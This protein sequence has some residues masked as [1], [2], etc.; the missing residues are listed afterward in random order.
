LL[1]PEYNEPKVTNLNPNEIYNYK[2]EFFFYHDQSYIIYQKQLYGMDHIAFDIF[3]RNLEF[4]HTI[5]LKIHNI[6][7]HSNGK[8]SISPNGRYI[9]YV[10]EVHETEDDPQTVGKL[11]EFMMDP[12]DKTFGFKL[13]ST[14]NDFK[15]R[16]DKMASE[17][18]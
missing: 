10:E 9:F 8:I 11:C 5:K 7:E 4:T 1:L 18:N 12:K 16:Y 15:E 14:I 3:N 17:I 13:I 6:D 2:S